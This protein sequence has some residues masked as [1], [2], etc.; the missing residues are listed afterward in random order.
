MLYGAPEFEAGDRKM[1]DIYNEALA[2][3]HAVYDYAKSVPDAG[4]CLFAWKVAGSALCKFHAM[5]E[6][7]N[8]NVMVCVPS[9]L[10]EVMSSKRVM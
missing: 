7:E 2:L 5:K 4:K 10:Q 9:V 3:Y 6:T 1:G 8:E